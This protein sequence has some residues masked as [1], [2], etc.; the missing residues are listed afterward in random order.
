MIEGLTRYEAQS[1]LRRRAVERRSEKKAA[2]IGDG[3]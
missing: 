3:D 2:L 1:D